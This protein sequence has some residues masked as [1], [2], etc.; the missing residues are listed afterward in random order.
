MTEKKRG[1]PRKRARTNK[2][3]FVA[4]NPNTTQ[5]EAYMSEK[6]TFVD[7]LKNYAKKIAEII[8]I[9]KI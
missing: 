5:N 9:R 4:D 8:R 2:G 3:R 6:I 1:R 7:R